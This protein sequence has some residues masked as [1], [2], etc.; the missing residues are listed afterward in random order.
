MAKITE[1]SDEL[2]FHQLTSTSSMLHI[3]L[4]QRPYVWTAKQ[5]DRMVSEIEA[6]ADKEDSSRFLGAIIA[7]SRP[8][9]P[10]RPTPHEIVDGQ[11][12]LTTLYLF[13]LAAAHVAAR[14]GKSD[15]AS[16][17]INKYLIID[18]AQDLPS[19]T[20]LQPSFG[21]RGQFSE[22]FDR[23]S[24]SGELADWLPVKLKL[25]STQ[26]EKDGLLI[27]QYTRIHKYLL[28]SADKRGFDRLEQI[29]DIVSNAMTF[30]FILLKDP[31]SA[32]TVFEGLNDPGVP[33]SVGDLV[34]NEIF[35]KIGYDEAP[36]KNLHDNEWVPFKA[37]FGDTFNDY[38]FPYCVI[39]KANTSR[40]EMFSELRKLWSGLEAGEIIKKLDEYSLPFL[41]L[42]GRER[43]M[44]EFGKPVSLAIRRLVEL[45][46]PSS[47]YPFLMRLLGE[48]KRGSVSKD[49]V[50]ACIETLESFLVRRAICGIEPTGLLG[51]F[52]TMWSLTGDH[53]TRE[54]IT[55]VILKRLTVEWPTDKRLAEAIRTRPIYGSSIAR[56][57]VLEYDRSQGGDHPS[58]QDFSIEHIMPRSHTDAWGEVIPKAQH[59]KLKDLWAN[60]VPLSHTMNGSVDKEPF[61]VKK[62]VFMNE[63]MFASTRKLGA[64]YQKW[65][66]EEIAKRSEIISTWAVTRWSRPAE[67]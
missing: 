64:E 35:S 42:Q 31:G 8:T 52:R 39:L 22:I 63:S 44:E 62:T 14:H 24:K 34:K 46:H 15:Y 23:V 19:N 47:T 48:F 12:R 10:S 65:D 28:D 67:A 41:A 1:N 17:L 3:P 18:W 26:R 43:Y 36:A 27:K 13:L 58:I 20:K 32:T 49:D 66:E 16:G 59:A 4:F 57:A 37:K 9:H 54:K 51:L 5:L 30:V 60:L 40:T 25:Q 2:S 56:Y 11:Q 7:V 29:V 38:F 61:P 33:I 21:D 55:S 50:L 45:R 53:P 6:I